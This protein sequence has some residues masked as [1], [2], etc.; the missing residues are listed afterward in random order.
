MKFE[1]EIKSE[2]RKGYGNVDQVSFC[3][4]GRIGFADSVPLPRQPW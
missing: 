4:R 3:I 1:T 2:N